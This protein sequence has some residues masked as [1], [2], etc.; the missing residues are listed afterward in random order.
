MIKA[1]SN[2][3]RGWTRA[4]LAAA[5][6]VCVSAMPFA[7]AAQTYLPPPGSTSAADQEQNRVEQLESQLRQA[8]ADNERL[9]YQLMQAQQEI[10]RLQQM[11]G[12]LA[13]TNNSL[14]Q[15]APSA[16][17]APA[18]RSDAAPPATPA[19]PAASYS[20]ARQLLLNGQTAEAEI[21]F[22]NF[23]R[24]NPNA[25]TAPDA[26]YWLS[27][28][29]LARNDY[30]AAASGFVDYL[31][32]Y[33]Q[34]ARAPEAQVRLGMALAGLGRASQAC[35]AFRDMPTRYPRASQAARDLAARESR[36]ARCPA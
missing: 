3:S 11:T 12:D 19:D 18:P 6:L 27:F 21:A 30:Q 4:A 22:T 15:P 35:A 23:L 31:Q 5:G 26:R 33:P 29:H 28:T 17:P 13:A 2:A 14:Q 9:Q 36:T 24:D 8:T 10:A 16:Q 1:S 7:A 20:A 32:R 25:Q 34:G